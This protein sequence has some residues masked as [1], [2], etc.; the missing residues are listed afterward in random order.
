MRRLKLRTCGFF[1]RCH[2]LF[3]CGSGFLLQQPSESQILMAHLD[4]HIRCLVS[5]VLR[6][7]IHLAQES[8]AEMPQGHCQK[9][10]SEDPTPELHGMSA[11]SSMYLRHKRCHCSCCAFIVPAIS[12]VS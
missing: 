11:C 12:G 9:N 1:C 8:P 4:G 5:Q 10:A 3:L 7:P 2:R 6:K